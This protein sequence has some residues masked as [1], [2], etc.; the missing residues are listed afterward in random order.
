MSIINNAD[1]FADTHQFQLTKTKT[2][3]SNNYN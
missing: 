1:T 3:K 2:K